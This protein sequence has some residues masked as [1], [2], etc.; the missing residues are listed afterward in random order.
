MSALQSFDFVLCE[1]VRGNLQ[2]CLHDPVIRKRVDQLPEEFRGYI[3]ASC[4]FDG[5]PDSEPFLLM[6]DDE[7]AILKSIADLVEP[8]QDWV[9]DS[10]IHRDATRCTGE[11]N[12]QL[13]SPEANK[14][15]IDSD[16]FARNLE[17]G[18]LM[19]AEGIDCVREW[20]SELRRYKEAV[21]GKKLLPYPDGSMPTPSNPSIS[22]PVGV[23]ENKTERDLDRMRAA[24]KSMENGKKAKP[25][26]L[27]KTAKINEQRGRVA[28][29]RLQ[30][31]NEYSGF[32]K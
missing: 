7:L 10:E 3:L 32:T 16:R 12:R 11:I 20:L 19:I 28:L 5:P 15:A 1:Y 8:P 30:E 21:A 13:A 2:Q 4:K 23:S 31:L 27:I 17:S 14:W 24:I 9:A 26:S 6:H 18:Q 22:A 25:K 29:R